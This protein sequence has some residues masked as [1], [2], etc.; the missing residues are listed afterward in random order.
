MIMYDSLKD[1]LD[2]GVKQYDKIVKK[3]N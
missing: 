2:K 3:D 1:G